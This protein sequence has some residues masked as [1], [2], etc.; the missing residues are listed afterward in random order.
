MKR[1][2]Y[3]GWF[4]H[5]PPSQSRFERRLSAQ[6]QHDLETMLA[7]EERRPKNIIDGKL[8]GGSPT[9]EGTCEL[10]K[11]TLDE[12]SMESPSTT[13]RTLSR[14]AAWFLFPLPEDDDNSFE[15]NEKYKKQFRDDLLHFSSDIKE[16][17][18]APAE[19]DDD[20]STDD[21]ES[22]ASSELTIGTYIRRQAQQHEESQNFSPDSRSDDIFIS[23]MAAAY[24]A[25]QVGEDFDR[26]LHED[27]QISDRDYPPERLDHVITQMD[28]ARMAKNASRH[29]DV[30]SILS[31]P[32][33]TY[34]EDMDESDKGQ[35]TGSSWMIIPPIEQDVQ[36]AGQVCVI[37]MEK[38]CNGDRLRVLPC[39][40]SF[41]VGCIDRWLSG[42]H[43]FIDCD[44]RGCPTCKKCPKD[45][46]TQTSGSV[47]SWAFAS[48]GDALANSSN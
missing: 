29:L 14:L 40:H 30:E 31:L 15:Y 46:T 22:D 43:S 48:V 36:K 38:F 23:S 4:C 21:D 34:Q 2:P 33:I 3:V 9:W 19:S 27:F 28:I 8:R 10:V 5:S 7:L 44:T 24:H 16:A 32:I 37:C 35:E 6:F 12:T 1:S 18:A 39:C 45:S 47:P 41:H 20:C 42:S 11:R 13:I 25:H 26:L 17:T